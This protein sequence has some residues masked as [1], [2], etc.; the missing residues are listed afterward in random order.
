MSI[1]YRDEFEVEDYIDYDYNEPIAT[2]CAIPENTLHSESM[3]STNSKY[4][5]RISS[6]SVTAFKDTGGNSSRKSVDGSCSNNPVGNATGDNSSRRSTDG[7]SMSNT[8][9]CIRGS[10]TN[11]PNEGMELKST[12][13][14]GINNSNG[15]KSNS[16]NFARKKSYNTRSK[17]SHKKGSNRE[18]NVLCTSKLTIQ[19]VDK[20]S[21]D[22]K[23]GKKL[24]SSKSSTSK[25]KIQGTNDCSKDKK[26]GKK[27]LPV[28]KDHVNRSSQSSV[29]PI[30]KK[31]KFINEKVVHMPLCQ[32]IILMQLM[33]KPIYKKNLSNGTRLIQCYSKP[34]TAFTKKDKLLKIGH[35]QCKNIDAHLDSNHELVSF[36][37]P[38][39]LES[40]TVTKSNACRKMNSTQGIINVLTESIIKQY[41]NKYKEY[42]SSL[43][44]R[45]LCQSPTQNQLDYLEK[46]DQTEKKS[47]T[48]SCDSFD[49]AMPEFHDVDYDLSSPDT[50]SPIEIENIQEENGTSHELNHKKS[51]QTDFCKGQSSSF[52][53]RKKS[54]ENLLKSTKIHGSNHSELNLQK[55]SKV[56]SPNKSIKHR[57]L[58]TNFPARLQ[59]NRNNVNSKFTSSKGFNGRFQNRR[60][61]HNTFNPG[62]RSSGHPP[63]S[64]TNSGP[65]YNEMNYHSS[66]YGQCFPPPPPQIPGMFHSH[67]QNFPFSQPNIFPSNN[68]FGHHQPSIHG[69][70]FVPVPSHVPPP[71]HHVINHVDVSHR[72][73]ISVISG[74]STSGKVPV[75][76]KS[77][78][79]TMK[80]NG[81]IQ[82]FVLMDDNLIQSFK[83][84]EYYPVNDILVKLVKDENF[85]E[86]NDGFKYILEG[87][88][89]HAQLG[90]S[91]TTEKSSKSPNHRKRLSLSTAFVKSIYPYDKKLSH[92][93][94]ETFTLRKIISHDYKDQ[95]IV[96]DIE[97][98]FEEIKCQFMGF[99][100][101]PSVS[102]TIKDIELCDIQWIFTAGKAG[103]IVVQTSQRQDA[104]DKKKVIMNVYSEDQRQALKEISQKKRLKFGL[105]YQERHNQK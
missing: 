94:L 65:I 12:G 73:D 103:H 70:N 4:K 74:N 55:S 31:K 78:S 80:I 50:L 37:H 91:S 76:P 42:V 54:T 6:T 33:I 43:S 88:S 9:N 51:L 29:K 32:Y 47:I 77:E 8:N 28:S 93:L 44:P 97:Y 86:S 48:H 5:L 100:V 83:S 104:I 41:R 90:S 45:K 57:N 66:N 75:K 35:C 34:C 63:F 19:G 40:V 95:I 96:Y 101:L 58:S 69:N 105:K 98:P 17:C 92:D 25:H 60:M 2:D 84:D 56:L 26:R 18:S 10:S 14:D 3:S 23:Q 22:K 39:Y 67:H 102:K 49:A 13:N 89:N 53:N 64:H 21:K 85:M 1:I 30:P 61:H 79:Y 99:E 82:K 52:D 7:M 36:I 11:G 24:T 68:N 71:H 59:S 81:K 27:P 20:C 72:G 16:V 87:I 62:N 46:Q 15:N 38:D